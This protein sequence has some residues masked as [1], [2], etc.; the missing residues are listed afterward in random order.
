[1]FREK[2]GRRNV[3]EGVYLCTKE[4]QVHTFKTEYTLF[5]LPERYEKYS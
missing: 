3:S 1:M 2:E 4:K 5:I